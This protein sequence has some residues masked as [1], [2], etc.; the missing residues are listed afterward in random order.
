[1]HLAA[2]LHGIKIDVAHVVQWIAD[3][4]QCGARSTLESDDPGSPDPH[5]WVLIETAGGALSPINENHTNLDLAVALEPS[6]WVLVG[7]DRLGVLHD[8]RAT[9]LAMANLTRLPDI[10]NT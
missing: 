5:G 8:M 4:C 6:Y 2:R 9:L 7:A 1:M 10:I 3:R